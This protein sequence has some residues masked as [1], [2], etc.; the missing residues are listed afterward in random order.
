[1]SADRVRFRIASSDIFKS[2]PVF[3]QAKSMTPVTHEVTLTDSDIESAKVLDVFLTII[4]TGNVPTVL[5]PRKDYSDYDN[6]IRL[7]FKTLR[8]MQKYKCNNAI[9]LLFLRLKVNFYETNENA[10]GLF[11][12]A[13]ANDDDGTCHC[14]IEKQ[15]HFVWGHLP[16]APTIPLDATAKES[17]ADLTTLRWSLCEIFPPVYRWALT[18]AT[19]EVVALMDAHDPALGTC[20]CDPNKLSH[21]E[22]VSY[23]FCKLMQPHRGMV[24]RYVATTL[25]TKPGE[26]PQNTK[27]WTRRATSRARHPL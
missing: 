16:H 20:E 27:S 2:S 15:K 1:M 17:L 19:A 24:P 4:T 23:H 21:R 13:A 10:L 8:F 12:L 18:G 6:C 11:I 25:T 22:T 26:R 3:D 14:I 7:L 9:D 5:T